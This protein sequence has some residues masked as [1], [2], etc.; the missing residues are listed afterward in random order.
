MFTF[1]WPWAL[2]AV[3]ASGG[4]GWT[5]ALA[6][7]AILLRFVVAWTVGRGLLRDRQVARFLP[8]LPLRDLTTVLV[9]I[10]SFASNTVAWRGDRFSLQGGKLARIDPQG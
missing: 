1:G 8:L 6:A 3:I 2:L 10:T 4:A 7:A 5:C 9:W